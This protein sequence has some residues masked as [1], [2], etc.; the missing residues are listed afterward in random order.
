MVADFMSERW[1]ASNRNTWPAS[2]G[3]RMDQEFRARKR[4]VGPSWRMDETYVRVKGAWKY[5]YR[6]HAKS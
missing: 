2:V 3:I 5:L 6:E 4:P 1:P